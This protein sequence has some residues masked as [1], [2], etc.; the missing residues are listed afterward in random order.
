MKYPF[1]LVALAGALAACG[2]GDDTS[3][4]PAP[5]QPTFPTVIDEGGGVIA[6]PE[7]YPIVY[8][9]DDAA[10]LA[11]VQDFV[12]TIGASSYWEATTKEYGVGPLTGHPAIVVPT[13]PDAALDSTAI[14]AWVAARLNADDPTFPEAGP[15]KLFVIF[16]PDG[17]TISE[18]KLGES[19]TGFSGYH[20]VTELDAAHGGKL[21]PFA[22]IPR[23][24][25]I[26]AGAEGI[27]GVTAT[28]SHELIET[29]T[30]PRLQSFNQ[31]DEDHLAWD[32]H[33][34]GELTDLCGLA[35]PTFVK[36][37]PFPYVVQRSWSNAAA[38]GLH[39]P[40]F[41]AAGPVYFAAAPVLPDSVAFFGQ[42]VQI[43]VGETKTVEIDL[44]AD[45]DP[46]GPWKVE[47]FDDAQEFLGLDPQ[48]AFK[49]DH[50]S[51]RRGDKL[52][53]DIT[54]L[55]GNDQG[56]EIFYVVST[57]GGVE[58]AWV[59]VVGN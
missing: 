38:K 42:G 3:T 46:G 1:L 11:T 44:F 59:G 12:S 31:V 36:A 49:L 23:C 25:A 9:G 10:T 7:V 14:E 56:A 33:Y 37:P 8:A 48:L 18:P 35:V 15:G 17:V 54:V 40:C 13:A 50:D 53:A 32:A 28:A 27:D 26:G 34:G 51:G 57:L 55:S 22:V 16:Y 20:D 30:D 6:S 41:P 4:T 45:G 52:H 5:F 29:V 58:N 47:L 24:L 2:G 19:C 21:V 39:D 43:P